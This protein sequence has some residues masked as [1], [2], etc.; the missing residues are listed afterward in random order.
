MQS[1][2]EETLPSDSR[3][4][5]ETQNQAKKQSLKAKISNKIDL[6]N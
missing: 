4:N 1:T 5:S 2:H 6:L 3:K